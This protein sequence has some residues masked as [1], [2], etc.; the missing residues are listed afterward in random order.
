[1][2]KLGNRFPEYFENHMKEN[3]ILATLLS[4]GNKTTDNG[5]ENNDSN[6]I[7]FDEIVQFSLNFALGR[8][9]QLN[10]IRALSNNAKQDRKNR[11]RRIK[12]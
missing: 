12:F 2:L 5:T 8:T 10:K 4:F 3:A 9:H 6:S 7:I 1:M 11:R